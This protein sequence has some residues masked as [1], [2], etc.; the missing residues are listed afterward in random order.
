MTMRGPIRLTVCLLALAVLALGTTDAWAA[1]RNKPRAVKAVASATGAGAVASATATCPSES[2][3]GPWRAVSGGFVLQQGDGVVHESRRVGERSWR[4]KA[5]S[6]SG[7]INLAAYVNCQRGVSKPKALSSSVPTPAVSQIGP[8]ATAKCNLGSAVSGGFSTPAPFT[9]AG[10]A[11]TVIGSFPSGKRA[12]KAQVVSNQAGSV[13]SLVYC[14]KRDAKP[15]TKNAKAE[16]SSVAT[17]GGTSAVS[18]TGFCP[19]ARFSPGGGGFFQSGATPSQYLIPTRST[20]RPS[21]PTSNPNKP[22]P[23]GY[24]GNVWVAHGLKVGSGTPVTMIA[25]ALCA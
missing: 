1:K 12:W 5:Q 17:L 9:G 7:S 21:T 2:S 18:T 24:L 3:K 22:P 13:T 15:K 19:A 16:S 25:V 14:A 20:Q 6:L 8:V 4:A 11:N 23:P 10:A